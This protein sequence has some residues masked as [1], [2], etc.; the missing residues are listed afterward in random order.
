MNVYEVGLGVRLKEFGNKRP[1]MKEVT[2]CVLEKGTAE[3]AIR[4]AKKWA[5]KKNGW[6]MGY[7]LSVKMR[8]VF[9]KCWIDVI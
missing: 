9:Q 6:D 7:P 5:M 8:S 4:K 2:I 1:I 3:A